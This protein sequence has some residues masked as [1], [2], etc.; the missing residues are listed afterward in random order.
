MSKLKEI[1]GKVVKISELPNELLP[2]W[3]II[4]K[5]GAYIECH[6]DDDMDDAITEWLIKTHPG[7]EENTFFI[8]ID[9]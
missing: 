8:E 6:I 7:I 1:N 3:L 4:H 5:R 9:I 2:D